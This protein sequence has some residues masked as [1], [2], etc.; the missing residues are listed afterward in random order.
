MNNLAHFFF[1]H[2]LTN[3]LS[4]I[5]LTYTIFSK[6]KTEIL[7]RTTGVQH[8]CHVIKFSRDLNLKSR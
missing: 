8:Q 5:F 6:K 4:Q 3:K 2:I 1:L 7:T